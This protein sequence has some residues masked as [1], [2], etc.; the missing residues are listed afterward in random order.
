[1]RT[2]GVIIT[3]LSWLSCSG[4]SQSGTGASNSATGDDSLEEGA[5]NDAE[6]ADTPVPAPLY[7]A[8][9]EPGRTFAYDVHREEH[10]WDD[11]NPTA[12]AD[13]MVHNLSDYIMTCTVARVEQLGGNQVSEVACDGGD[14]HLLN[15]IRGYYAATA[16]GLCLIEEMPAS[17]EQLAEWSQAGLM[18]MLTPSPVARRH[19]MGEADWGSLVVISEGADGSWCSAVS[20]WGGDEGTVRLC[21]AE[22]RG[23]TEAVSS[24]A[25]GSVHELS[26]TLRP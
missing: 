6:A 13:G 1:M 15:V 3:A 24:W 20:F 7:A 9:F 16:E 18:C 5:S 21:V 14:D 10:Y 25:G 22:G 26:A 4:G 23:I 2:T 8:L 17:A 11:A 19:E 12:D